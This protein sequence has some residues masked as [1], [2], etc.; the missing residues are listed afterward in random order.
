MHSLDNAK[1]STCLYFMQIVLGTLANR[2][3]DLLAM[4]THFI[5][6]IKSSSGNVH[7]H[8]GFKNLASIAWWHIM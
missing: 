4:P 1:Y 6:P 7:V 8:S 5:R 3:P 2:I